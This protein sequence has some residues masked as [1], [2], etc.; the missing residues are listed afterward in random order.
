MDATPSLSSLGVGSGLDMGKILERLMA[1]ERQPLQRLEKRKEA[2]EARISAVGRLRSALD[3]FRSVLKDLADVQRFELYAASSSDETVVTAQA[4]SS[5]PTGSYSIQVKRLA[6]QHKLA[7]QTTYADSDTTTIGTAGDTMTI[8]L[9]DGSSTTI[10]YGGKTLADIASAI[11]NDGNNPGVSASVIRDNTGYRLLLTAKE[12][13]SGGLIS[14]TYGSADP[15]NLQTVNQDR[16]GSGSFTAQDLDAELVVDG[17]YTLTTSSNTVTD[18]IG[19]ITL[20]LQGAGTATV[21]VERDVE[22]IKEQAQKLVDAYN[23]LRET[24]DELKGGGLSGEGLLLALE[25]Q[26]RGVL[27]TPPS[28]I[29]SQYSYLAQVG[30]TLQKDGTMALEASVLET[31]LANDFKGVAQVLANDNQG[32]LFRLDAL[33][34]EYTQINGLLDSKEEGLQASV[35][36]VERSIDHMEERLLRIELRYR[37]QF[38][39]LD[40]LVAQLQSTGSFIRARLGTF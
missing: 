34:Q 1:V 22:G 3:D 16:D 30:I 9:P 13:G 23:K 11:N 4:G 2:F 33:V 40:G 25:R 32:Y 24:L 38:V 14:V 17:S 12:T 8:S 5:A 35:D 31:A 26:I 37:S 36:N 15:F 20:E 18:A 39:M 10:S 19:G 28:G 21:T 7:A 29:A 6:E 27:N